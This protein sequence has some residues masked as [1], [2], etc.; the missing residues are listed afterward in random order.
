M[1]ARDP[2]LDRDRMVIR[3]GDF[4]VRTFASPPF[5]VRGP[6]GVMLDRLVTVTLPAIDGEDHKIVPRMKVRL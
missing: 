5:G 3:G 6:S 2:D 4:T 1:H